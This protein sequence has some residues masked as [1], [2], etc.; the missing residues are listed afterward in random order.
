MSEYTDGLKETLEWARQM[1]AD[2][3]HEAHE[4]WARYEESGEE[5]DYLAWHDAE[6][7]RHHYEVSACRLTD[8]LVEEAADRA[9][10]DE[11]EDNQTSTN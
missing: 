11:P 7:Q 1:E 4:A 8:R 5:L 6:T 10:A 2:Y 3:E 9:G